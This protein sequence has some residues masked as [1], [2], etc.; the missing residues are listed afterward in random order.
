MTHLVRI[1]QS[2]GS[3][4]EVRNLNVATDSATLGRGTDQSIQIADKRVPLAHS[5]LTFKD[6]GIHI[7]ANG[8]LNFAVNNQTKGRADLKPGDV[9]DVLGH[10]I[11]VLE[12]AGK[13]ILEI[14]LRDVEK[15]AL[16]DKF[17]TRLWQLNIPTR[18]FSWVLFLLV[19]AIGI[20][21]P[22]A[23]FLTGMQPLRDSPLP[24]DGIWLAGELHRT[25]A[26]MGDRC[27]NCHTVP[28]VPA[29]EVDCLNCH[30]SVNHHFDTDTFGRD[31]FI[32]DTCQDCHREHNGPE[33]ITRTDQE[34]C[35]ACHADLAHAGYESDLLAATDFL[36]DHP[37][38]MVSML[39]M[40]EDET[41][42]LKRF[43][44][45]DDELEEVSNLKFPHDIHM[46]PD[47][48]LG[49]E[50]DIVME[51]MDCH[52]VEKGGMRMK[53]VT[54]EQHCASCHELTFDPAAP[55]RVVPH[56]A[57]DDLMILLRGYYAY[58]YF[59]ENADPGST[60]VDVAPEPAREVRRPGRRKRSVSE[61][62]MEIPNDTSSTEARDFV[63][64][65]VAAAA[66]RMFEQR[67]CIVCHEVIEPQEES[68]DWRVMPVKLTPDWMPLAEFSHDSHINM[69][70]EG[71]HEAAWSDWAGD[72]L[73]P[74]IESCRTCHG[75]EHAEGKLQSSCISCHEFHL[76]T[77]GPMG[78]LLAIDEY[79]FLIDQF[80]NYVDE[81][82][83]ILP[84][85]E[86][87]LIEEEI[88]AIEEEYYEDEEYFENEEYSEDEEYE[89]EY[90]EEDGAS[91]EGDSET[92]N[93]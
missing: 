1:I 3:S 23:G 20:I 16:R 89:E 7:R 29:Q 37:A 59:Q 45:W 81:E 65:R 52:A 57:P 71:C 53:T 66:E 92:G 13:F 41:W 88:R 75:G 10:E 40:Q 85:E 36:E 35:T 79:G 67:S 5:T 50:G 54:M 18:T 14:H 22:S 60:T 2:K 32:G 80:G 61:F 4:R 28:F 15:E 55:D 17:T 74:D 26:F 87:P 47:G 6:D 24:D 27:E 70:C 51:C 49:P 11:H 33:A 39:E 30:L 21:I 56:G 63:D 82:G 93:T 48:V 69:S 91:D 43:D 62:Q 25:H 76:D 78:V 73:M 9:V 12:E 38:F 34:S 44:M 46:N 90:Y 58:Q 83:N 64:E 31:Y 84:P 19:I 8:S 86:V 77:Q 68:L 42:D 72:V